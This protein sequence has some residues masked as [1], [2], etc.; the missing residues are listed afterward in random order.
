[1]MDYD[2]TNVQLY[3]ILSDERETI[4]LRDKH[5]KVTDDLSNDL[6]NWY[7]NYPHTFD[8]KLIEY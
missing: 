2:Y 4:N 3:D 6:M 5:P 7:E 8:K 1:M